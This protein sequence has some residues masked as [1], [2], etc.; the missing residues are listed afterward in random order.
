MDSITVLLLTTSYRGYYC[1]TVSRDSP[2]DTQRRSPASAYPSW[3][4]LGRER[5]GLRFTID[6]GRE[7]WCSGPFNIASG[8]IHRG[9]K[10]VVGMQLGYSCSAGQASRHHV[11]VP[12]G[13]TYITTLTKGTPSGKNRFGSIR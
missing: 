12:V 4:K 5:L 6:V 1:H 8:S 10:L 9:E 2:G 11:A 3:L 7:I 13:I